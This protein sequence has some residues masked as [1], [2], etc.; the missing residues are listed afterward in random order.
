MKNKFLYLFAA[1]TLM[2]TAC[3]LRED[4]VF[5]ESADERLGAILDEYSSALVD[6]P[7]GWIM[8]LN[9]NQGGYLLYMVFNEDGRVTMLSDQEA[10]Y[11]SAGATS[12]VPKESSYKIK[13]I[14]MP[15]ILF[16]TYNYLHK[17]ADPGGSENGGT[18]G[19]G[20]KTDFE[21][22]I[23]NYS[24]GTF[25]LRGTFNKVYAY[26]R[27]AT[28]EEAEAI[29]NGGLKSIYSTQTEYMKSMD[30]ATIG[31]GDVKAM[32][33]HNGRTISLSYM[34]EEGDME[35]AT[36][37]CYIDLAS[38][39]NG[40]PVNNIYL[41]EP[42]EFAGQKITSLKWNGE[43]LSSV[44]E[45][46][47]EVMVADNFV[48][49]FA[50]PL[51]PGKTYNQIFF[52]DETEWAGTMSEAYRTSHYAAAVAGFKK[53]NRTIVSTQCTFA[54]DGVGV[55][56]MR[57]YIQ[58]LNSAGSA[59]RADYYVYYTVNDDGSI[60]FTGRSMSGSNAYNYARFDLVKLLDIFCEVEYESITWNSTTD[61]DAVIKSVVPHTFKSDWVISNTPGLS[62]T[63]G[64]F[65]DVDNPD[66]FFAGA[67]SYGS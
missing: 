38:I 36:S 6:A 24:G 39:V 9:T 7:N 29:M 12:S 52:T 51:G 31:S 42:L 67:V 10:T 3:D 26:L 55:P 35:D 5:T 63:L 48:P 13:S 25:T 32:F 61:F 33:D 40:Q 27:H 47:N 50:L 66:M 65:Y 21:F 22:D 49:P 46:G 34:T 11:P 30:C 57:V 58:T 64:K 20:L 62:G 8:A 17:M 60:T 43:S 45:S 16:D 37:S 44:S 4:R 53:Q 15:S 56:A 23:I 59:Y 28:G 19:T 18:N 14:Q 41:F 1:V 54:A 2:F